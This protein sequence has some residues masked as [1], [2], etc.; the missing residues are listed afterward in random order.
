MRRVTRP[1]LVLLAIVFLVEAWLWRHLE[2]IVAWL[3]ACLPLRAVKRWLT[4]ALE[5]L[6]PPAA[7]IVFAVPA[8]L[9]FPLKLAAI[10]FL[11]HQQWIAAAMV[12]VVAKLGG[13]GITAFLFEVTKPKLMTMGWFRWLYAR[14]LLALDWAHRLVDPIKRR[15]QALLRLFAPKRASRMMRLFWRVRRQMRPARI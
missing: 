2:P 14:V 11:A 4:A 5:W 3:V 8:A 9:L 6:P 10:W 12:L 7:L 1:L 13:V 15:A